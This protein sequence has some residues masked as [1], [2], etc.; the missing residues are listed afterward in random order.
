MTT[1][2]NQNDKVKKLTKKE[3]LLIRKLKFLYKKNFTNMP[4][5]LETENPTARLL[6]TPEKVLHDGL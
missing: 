6:T 4:E 3:N 1:A 2:K 5:A